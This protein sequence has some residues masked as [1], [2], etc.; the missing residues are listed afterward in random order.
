M[1]PFK[2]QT[3]L[4]F[5]KNSMFN[6]ARKNVL[7]FNPTTIWS[8]AF[9]QISYLLLNFIH[10]YLYLYEWWCPHHF[11]LRYRIIIITHWNKFNPTK[12]KREE[13]VLISLQSLNRLF[14]K[15][16]YR[17]WIYFKF[18][19][20]FLRILIRKKTIIINVFN[21]SNRE[22]L[23]ISSRKKITKSTENMALTKFKALILFSFTWLLN[24]H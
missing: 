15:L 24:K 19:R 6:R 21:Y 9:S 11:I 10:E 13:R 22:T 17:R 18:W 2:S 4:S 12:K 23:F 7:N 14:F 20:E 16:V 5:D 8:I 3:I 1:I